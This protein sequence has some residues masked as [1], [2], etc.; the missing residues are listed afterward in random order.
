MK[1]KK[2]DDASRLKRLLY[3][4]YFNIPKSAFG[5]LKTD[6]TNLLKSYFDLVENSVDLSVEP[7]SDGNFKLT[8]TAEAT[9][10][11]EIK[12]LN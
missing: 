4:D 10:I 7:D 8:L 6:I 3:N 5:V 2:S 9:Q 1:I 11:K 12:I